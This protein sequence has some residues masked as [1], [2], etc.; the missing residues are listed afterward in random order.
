MGQLKTILRIKTLRGGMKGIEEFIGS[1][2]VEGT[3][4]V[5]SVSLVKEGW[6]LGEGRFMDECHE[7]DYD[8]QG[9]KGERVWRERME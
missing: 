9:E 2:D 6:C 1:A 3:L 8:G 7:A 4:R 5:K